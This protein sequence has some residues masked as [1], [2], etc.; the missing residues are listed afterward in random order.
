MT[1]NKLWASVN[2]FGQITIQRYFVFVSTEELR[3]LYTQEL[4]YMKTLC[5]CILKK[6]GPASYARTFS[7]KR[8][9][10]NFVKVRLYTMMYSSRKLN[11]KKVITIA[12]TFKDKLLV[13]SRFM[14]AQTI[15]N[16]APN[17]LEKHCFECSAFFT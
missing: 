17:R 1:S 11:N 12:V 3:T 10:I 15:I 9:E 14:A 2:F 16:S 13:V 7:V 5:E 8:K 4:R 6:I